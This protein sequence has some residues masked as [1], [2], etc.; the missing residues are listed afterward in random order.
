MMTVEVFFQHLLAELNENRSLW[1]YHK[2]LTDER[3]IFFRKAY[4][5]QRLQYIIDHIGAPGQP[6]W[7]CGCG[8]GTTAL[9]LAMNGYPVKGT[10]LE[11]YY[12]QIPARKKF[13]SRFG[14]ADLFDC[15]YEDLFTTDYRSQ[16][17]TILVQ[18]TL[19]HLY[20]LGPALDVLHRSL[21]ENGRLIV[22][23][24]NGKNIIQRAKLL[25]HRGFNKRV[26]VWDEVLHKKLSFA[27]E[28]IRGY[29]SWKDLLHRH[30]FVVDDNSLAFIRLFPPSF[31]KKG[32]YDNVIRREKWI[33][34]KVHLL[35]T[36][37]YFGLNF[38]ARKSEKR[39]D[40]S[41]H[42]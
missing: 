29:R 21:S 18:D 34:R 27:D 30:G 12:E 26:E 14:D 36:Y 22:I 4:F 15:S 20:P 13:W 28:Q 11:F 16:F 1:P 35:N 42:P 39:I 17:S 24:E 19:H 32:I 9:F 31:F 37:F 38:I 41:L 10:T 3:K 23:E 5:C 40:L 33:S 25:K 7:D 6:V 8:Y 2:F